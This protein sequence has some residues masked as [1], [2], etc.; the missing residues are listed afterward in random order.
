MWAKRGRAREREKANEFVRN[1]QSTSALC[2]NGSNPKQSNSNNLFL[3]PIQPISIYNSYLFEHT[4]QYTLLLFFVLCSSHANATCYALQ[5]ALHCIKIWY[6]M[7]HWWRSFHHTFSKNKTTVNITYRQTVNI[8]YAFKCCVFFSSS[9]NQI[10]KIN[11]KF[12]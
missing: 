12:F 2:R 9:N 11:L 6:G 5:I 3:P 7:A 10:M 4:E 8:N 1:D